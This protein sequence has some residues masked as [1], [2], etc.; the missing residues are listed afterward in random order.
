M[1]KHSIEQNKIWKLY[2]S[3]ANNYSSVLVATKL[4]VNTK[5]TL[6]LVASLASGC[7]AKS[8]TFASFF[9]LCWQLID[10][11]HMTLICKFRKKNNNKFM[12]MSCKLLL[13]TDD[14]M[15]S[16][17]DVECNNWPQVTQKR[18]SEGEKKTALSGW[19]RDWDLRCSRGFKKN[20]SMQG[21]W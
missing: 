18:E 3:T 1:F 11:N 15:C 13:T 8:R 21:E 6:A 14:T 12:F 4:T 5:L 19:T 20:S 7:S 16:W 10:P 17:G 9:W 2:T